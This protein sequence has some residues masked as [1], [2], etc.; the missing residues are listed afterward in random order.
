MIIFFFAYL[1]WISDHRLFTKKTGRGLGEN[2]STMIW[3]RK[4][5]PNWV[6]LSG[7]KI[8]S[9]ELTYPT[10]GKGTSSSNMPFW[11]DMLVPRKGYGFKSPTRKTNTWL[12]CVS[13]TRK[14]LM[15]SFQEIQCHQQRLFQKKDPTIQSLRCWESQPFIFFLQDWKLSKKCSLKNNVKKITICNPINPYQPHRTGSPKR[16]MGFLTFPPTLTC[17]GTDSQTTGAAK[18]GQEVATMTWVSS[19]TQ[20]MDLTEIRPCTKIKVKNIWVDCWWGIFEW[21]SASAGGEG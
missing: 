4:N 9:R 10:L 12:L 16:G 8:P 20:N 14:P 6:N 13:Y 17:L 19:K 5:T 7:I 18:Q 15:T 3:P 11:R 1:R 21:F 2:N